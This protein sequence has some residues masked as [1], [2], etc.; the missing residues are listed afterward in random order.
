MVTDATSTPA[1]N[2]SSPPA[3]S[4]ASQRLMSLDALRGFDMFWI[5]GAGG[6][7]TRIN[8]I[9][10]S[11]PQPQV[12]WLDA[13]ARQLTHAKWEGFNFLDL[14]FPLFVFMIG[15]SIVYSL[16]RQL[17]ERG[18]A[19]AYV[20]IVRRFLLLFAMGVLATGGLTYRWPDLQLSGVL[21]RLAWCYLFG[22]IIFCHFRPRTIAVIVVLLLAGYWALLSYVPFPNVRLEETHPKRTSPNAPLASLDTQFAAADRIAG[23]YEQ[24]LNLCN[25]LDARYL[26]GRKSS[27]YY[28]PE[29]LLSTMTAVA[30]C[31]LGVLAGYLIRRP[32]KDWVKV[33]LLLGLG[34]AGVASGYVWGE[35]FPIIKKIWTSSYVLVAG[36]YSAILLGL[37]YLVIDVWKWRWWCLPFVW[38]GMNAI[39][40]YLVRQMVNV[41][42]IAQRLTGGDVAH[43]LNEWLGKGASGVL[44]SAVSF[45]LIW[46]LAF[47]LYRRKVFIRL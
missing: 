41:S 33:L 42:E 17:Q 32:G 24:G 43:W 7:V 34:A 20:R 11:G 4:G 3:G 15:V 28:S 18:K 25:Y 16:S 6:I 47:F 27:G 9:V 39:T 12:G 5:L 10:N 31:L 1:A 38:I 23:S 44:S 37:F 14:I 36:G 29:G 13:L 30:T 26:P 8:E 46:W 35:H 40:V 22:A 21:H 19:W 45:L 2:E